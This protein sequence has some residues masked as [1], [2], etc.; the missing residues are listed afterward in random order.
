MSPSTAASSPPRGSRASGSA[1]DG[2]LADRWA[3][4]LQVVGRIPFVATTAEAAA[5]DIVDAALESG[6]TGGEHL[7]FGNANNIAFASVDTDIRRSHTDERAWNLPDGKSVTVTSRLRR[8]RPRLRQVRGPQLLLDVCDLGRPGSLR[9]Y[10]LGGSPEMLELLTRS[11]ERRFPGVV[12]VGAE[13][14]PYRPATDEELAARDEAIRRSGAQIVWLGLG[15]PKQDLEGAR[16]AERLPVLVACVG[17][18]FDYAAGTRKPAPAYISAIGLE[19]FWR[20]CA[21]PRRLWRRY[22]INNARF[23]RAI[24]KEGRELRRDKRRDGA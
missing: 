22:T 1:A 11:L 17:A 14:P 7:H 20:L 15:S 2:V 23:I 4:R 16:L 6:R 9:H 8:H 19:W 21:E 24:A 12:I 18:A 10:L 13:S 3:G 5:R